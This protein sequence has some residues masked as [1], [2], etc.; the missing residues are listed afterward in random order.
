VDIGDL[1]YAEIE[2]QIIFLTRGGANLMICLC[3]FLAK[4]PF[5]LSRR[6]TFHASIPT[7]IQWGIIVF[8][9]PSSSST[10]HS[11]SLM[12]MAH[13][14][15]FPLTEL[16]ISFGNFCNS[17]ISILPIIWEFSQS[18]SSWITF[19]ASMAI[20]AA[21]GFPPYVEPCWKKKTGNINK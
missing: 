10:H 8:S 11:L 13:R 2:A 5:S 7:E 6:Q 20:R 3:V 19:N 9:I 21:N 15:P 18:R 16:T 17:V 12:T 14:R 1:H 4:T